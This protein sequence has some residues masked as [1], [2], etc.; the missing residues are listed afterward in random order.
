MKLLLTVFIILIFGGTAFTQTAK[1]DSLNKLISQASTDTARINLKNKKISIIS[2]IDIDS[3][4]ALSKQTVKEAI[5][6][7]YQ[8]GEA[9]ARLQLASNYCMKGT[10]PL[11]A[12]N[13]LLSKKIFLSLK[14]SLGFCDT[15][16]VYG[17]MYGMQSKYDTSITYLEKAIAVAERNKYKERLNA[18]Y[19]NLAIGYQMK[20]NYLKALEFY[21]KS[22]DLA[23][24]KK[25]T[26]AQAKTDLNMGS[27][28]INTGDT[29]RA[30]RFILEAI[31]LAKK[32]NLKNVELYGYTNL[33]ELYLE[34]QQPQQAYTYALQAANL[35]K[36]M[37][38]NGIRS[39]SLAKAAKSLAKMQKFT[40]ALTLAK[41][42]ITM[43][44]SSGQ[45]Y[46][47]YQAYSIMGSIL[48]QQQQYKAAIPFLEKGLAV[49][50]KTDFYG[51]D[52]GVTYTTLS[53]CYEK[54][55]Y[56]EKALS[57]YKTS[58]QIAD[59]IL[60]R[61]N[62]RK[63]TELSMNYEF[64]KKQEAQ[65]IE[66][67]NKDAITQARLLAV[68]I[69]FVLTLI[70]AMVAFRAYRNKQKANAQLQL[71]KEEI[72]KTL[73][74]LER[75]QAQLIQREKMASL[76]ELTAGIAHEIQNPL[77][78]INNFSE[79]NT[80]LITELKEEA[81]KGNLKEIKEIAANIEENEQKINQHGKRADNIVKGMLQHS[82]T[83]TGEKQLTP[84][85]A[86]TEEY[87]RLAYH[88]LRA[89]NKDFNTTLVTDLDKSLGKIEVAPQE[90]GRVL[91]NLFNNA[92]YAT[93]QKK[94]RLNGQYEPEVKVTTRQLDGS[95]QIRVRDNGMGI[96]ENVQSKIFQPF[97]TTKP[98]GQGTG[99]GLSLSYDIITKGHG[100]E[101]EMQSK[102]DIYTEFIIR[103]PL[104]NK[105]F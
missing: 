93:Q 29:I 103:L 49:L 83:S 105:E 91:L 63:T 69:I 54:T 64:N 22:L 13:L 7:H 1:L 81:D 100:G 62:I 19:S 35:G 104:K 71:Q 70:L 18:Y 97:F 15:Y 85:N 36:E 79:I 65:R 45:T 90:L 28:Y 87:L 26:V 59:S 76:G 88:G 9:T 33:A 21:Q 98:T 77:N 17:M 2:R 37:G 20:G 38:D 50:E 94:A 92:F 31:R 96:P 72:Q 68:L 32:E 16:S 5:N 58:K 102:E 86:L 82:R 42:A 66:Q 12:Q 47:R 4:I 23:K 57:F 41:Q 44:D 75:T 67:K 6:I 84:I 43:A 48:K 3:A 74:K 53:H 25:D 39:V 60:T 78:F 56:Y 27:A 24:E 80:E 46:N 10:Y 34:M 30:R 101:L 61:D 52:V 89:K 55:G 11:A 73:S 51:E 8:K 95:I 14:D 99:L 40:E